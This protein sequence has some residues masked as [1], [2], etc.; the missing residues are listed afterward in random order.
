MLIK[1]LLRNQNFA[2][3]EMYIRFSGKICIKGPVQKLCAYLH[4]L[5]AGPFSCFLGA[6]VAKTMV[7]L[8]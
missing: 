7:L 3:H 2:R 6:V 8:S 5:S 4:D 1:F